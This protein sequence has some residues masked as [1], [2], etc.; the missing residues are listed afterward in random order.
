M[1]DLGRQIV[2][3]AASSSTPASEIRKGF[4]QR[5]KAVR[6]GLGYTQEQMAYA[7]GIQPARY[8][9]YEIGR[10]EPPYGVLVDLAQ[11]GQ[12]D[13]DYLIAGRTRRRGQP[14][15]VPLDQLGDLL[16]TLP[17]PAVLFDREQRL[18]AHN[19]LYRERVV[20]QLPARLLRRGTPLEI[21]VR[22]FGHAH[23]LDSAV[24]EQLVR[25]R[26]DASLY[27]KAP[28]R[29]TVADRIF[30]FAETADADKRLVLITDL[31]SA[32]KH[33]IVG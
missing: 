26:L 11:V 19:Q 2:S 8:N 20:D 4:S 18:F 15:A 5:L 24:I 17:T 32:I 9:K 14:P 33:D 1:A 31:G 28:V 7:L 29:L 3:Q 21:L 25:L 27:R 10:S 22:A 16:A 12:V 23:D 30:Q 6:T 13:L